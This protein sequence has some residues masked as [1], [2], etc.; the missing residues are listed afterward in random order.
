MLKKNVWIH[1]NIDT[2]KSICFNPN[3]KSIFYTS[4][5]FKLFDF[6]DAFCFKKNR[7]SPFQN[8]LHKY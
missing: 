4:N 8:R 6:I 2:K 3:E 5:E 7:R 1:W